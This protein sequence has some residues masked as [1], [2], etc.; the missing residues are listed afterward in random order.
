LSETNR[1][2]FR[3]CSKDVGN[4]PLRFKFAVKI[5]TPRK[6]KKFEFGYRF[7]EI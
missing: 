4:V 1:R 7:L 6:S 5:E 2:F 3:L